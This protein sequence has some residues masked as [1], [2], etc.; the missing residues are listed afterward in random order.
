M[1]ISLWHSK[2][3]TLSH[4]GRTDSPKS[5]PV[6]SVLTAPQPVTFIISV[7]DSLA[8]KMNGNDH[9]VAPSLSKH[10]HFGYIVMNTGHK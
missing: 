6:Q 2:K 10:P 4:M 7:K 9:P 5:K 1:N 3:W 8:V